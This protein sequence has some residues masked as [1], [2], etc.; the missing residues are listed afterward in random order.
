MIPA[1]R[2]LRTI[3]YLP[4]VPLPLSTS[5]GQKTFS[6]RFQRAE[7]SVETQPENQDNMDKTHEHHE[8]TKGAM[9]DSFGEGYATRSDEEGFGGIYG[10]NQQLKPKTN[11]EE[12]TSHE[13]QPAEYDKTQGSEV[14]E[15]EKG[16][17]QTHIA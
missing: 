8:K 6:I 13:N 17:H 3:Q 10:G 16:R 12:E 15:K 4:L 9:S 7:Y 1:L 2:S 14:R 11:K 5:S